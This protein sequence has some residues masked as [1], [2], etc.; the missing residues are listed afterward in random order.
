MPHTLACLTPD[1]HTCPTHLPH[2][3]LFADAF[4]VCE[5]GSRAIACDA[6]T[7]SKLA[8]RAEKDAKELEDEKFVSSVKTKEMREELAAKGVS[9]SE[10]EKKH[11]ATQFQKWAAEY[12]PDRHEKVRWVL[13]FK[14]VDNDA[15]GLLTFD[16]VRLVIR[17]KFKVKKSEFSEEQIKVLWCL[18]DDDDSDHVAQVEFGRFLKKVDYSQLPVKEKK[19][20]SG[21]TDD[22]KRDEI[23]ANKNKREKHL[24]F[25][26][27]GSRSGYTSE[28]Y[29]PP[30]RESVEEAGGTVPTPDEVEELSKRFSTNTQAWDRTRGRRQR[31]RPAQRT[32]DT[33]LQLADESNGLAAGPRR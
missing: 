31:D 13:I 14:E 33:D 16:E 29:P 26:V 27:H 18:L 10:D 6:Q 25:D 5:F 24:A 23:M 3:C 1:P 30:T 22:W 15:S 32:C 19:S 17:Q 2:T 7:Q 9:A 4:L 8:L 28:K 11:F 20:W 12:M 21:K